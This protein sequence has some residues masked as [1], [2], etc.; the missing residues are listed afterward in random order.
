MSPLILHQVKKSKKSF[1]NLHT[2]ITISQK[3]DQV[4]LQKRDSKS[5]FLSGLEGFPIE[6]INEPP[7]NTSGEFKHTITNHKLTN[8]V[9]IK[10]VKRKKDTEGR[11]VTIDQIEN[12]ITTSLDKKA[13]KSIK[14]ILV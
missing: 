2:V 5:K 3:N 12:E 1:T 6:I 10:E 11:W 7:S 4:L 13:F 9:L 14:H 8:H